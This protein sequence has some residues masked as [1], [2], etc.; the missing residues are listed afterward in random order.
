MLWRYLAWCL[1]WWKHPWGVL[2]GSHGMF[3]QPQS[4]DVSSPRDKYGVPLHRRSPGPRSRRALQAGLSLIL[5]NALIPGPSS[6]L[7]TC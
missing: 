5:S 6:L 2:E 4:L 1:A 3:S 7:K